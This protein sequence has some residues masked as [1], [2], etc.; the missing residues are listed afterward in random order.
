MNS[1]SFESPEKQFSIQSESRTE[2]T[3]KAVR[4]LPM[5]ATTEQREQTV[6][7]ARA[8]YDQRIRPFLLAPVRHAHVNMSN[9]D[10]AQEEDIGSELDLTQEDEL[11]PNQENANSE[12]DALT[13]PFQEE[14]DEEEGDE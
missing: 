12:V 11:A 10:D 6:K 5:D 9:V 2:S 1:Q 4:A 7:R 3:A 8:E 13:S 14:F